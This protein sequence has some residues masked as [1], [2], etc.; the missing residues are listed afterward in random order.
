MQNSPKTIL[1]PLPTYGF[2]PTEVAIPWKVLTEAGKDVV[3]ATPD[4]T[5]G[6]PD[7]I[8]VTGKG[9]GIW[10]PLLR[11]RGDAVE[12]YYAMKETE[13]FRHPVKYVDVK[14]ADYDALYLPGG[15]DK[16]VKEYLES[17]LLHKTTTDFFAAEKPVAAIC[18]GVVV[19]AR[20]INPETGKSVIHGYKTTALLKSLERAGYNLTR[21][22]MGDYYL[23]YPETTVE[24]EV[25]AALASADDFIDG[26][27]A[28]FRDTPEK[29]E[30]GFTVR[31]RNY[32]S[33]RWPGDAYRCS[34]EF[35]KM[36]DA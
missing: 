15:H 23:T 27:P 28:M 31:D 29:L 19:A 11:A 22:W 30:R 3:F 1:I 6:T 9:L 24:D 26:P 10:K 12:A 25:R 21:M 34:I 18:H 20:S 7:A 2:D 5:E 36:I 16:R 8:M 35:D 32:I 17:D 14:E 33:A 13:A 4:G